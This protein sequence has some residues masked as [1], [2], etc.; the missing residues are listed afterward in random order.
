VTLC[1]PR[2][3][4]AR[5]IAYRAPAE[6]PAAAEVTGHIESTT[7]RGKP[8]RLAIEKTKSGFHGDVEIGEGDARVVRSFDARSCGAV[9]EA[10]ELALALRSDDDEE[11]APAPAVNGGPV[12]T[13][14]QGP[15]DR[16]VPSAPASATEHRTWTLGTTFSYSSFS[17]GR[18]LI[19]GALFADLALPSRLGDVSF[20]QPSVR[21][22]LGGTFPNTRT[23]DRITVAEGDTGYRLRFGGGPRLTVVKSALDVCPVGLG[24]EGSLSL[25][26][27]G[28]GELGVVF[29]D[30]AGT[31][32]TAP[33][34]LWMAAGP[35]VRSRFTWG[36]G[37]I[38]PAF[39]VT[40]GLL[41]PLRRDRFHFDS[42][43]TETAAPWVWTVGFGGGLVFP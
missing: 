24:L 8:A 12:A 5:D 36:S 31:T 40:A 17:E 35:V 37:A 11:S 32:A 14:E 25:A 1:L 30:V 27:C 19:G 2:A 18:N 34:Q 15:A 16:D 41:A 26:A 6:C 9:V 38:R 21:V 28:R 33:G 7:P 4:H 29:A 20:L 3:A 23:V 42:Y 13:T 43:P 10:L 39:E 22:S